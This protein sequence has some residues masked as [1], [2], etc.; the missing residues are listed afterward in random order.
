M[1]D[2]ITARAWDDLVSSCRLSLHHFGMA[3]FV[4]LALV[5]C[6]QVGRLLATIA[7]STHRAWGG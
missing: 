4:V 7:I 6:G 1:T 2:R 5:T 3:L